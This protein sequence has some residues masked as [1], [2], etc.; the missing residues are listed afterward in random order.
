MPNPSISQSTI[1]SPKFSPRGKQD[2]V[3]NSKSHGKK[4][5]NEIKPVTEVFTQI[6]EIT[7]MD[8]ELEINHPTNTAI[9]Q[10]EPRYNT[11]SSKDTKEVVENL[12]ST[13]S[14]FAKAMAASDPLIDALASSP[15]RVVSKVGTGKKGNQPAAIGSISSLTESPITKSPISKSPGKNKKISNKQP[16]MTESRSSAEKVFLIR[17]YF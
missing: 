9:E 16:G 3:Q 10:E 17:T 1:P 7:D 8:I 2:K 6:D 11:R 13:R 15:T 14:R 12:V 4:G 5:T